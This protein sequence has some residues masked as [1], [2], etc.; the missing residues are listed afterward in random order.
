M[1]SWAQSAA[2]AGQIV[3][4]DGK[5]VRQ[6]LHVLRA[7]PAAYSVYLQLARAAVRYLPVKNRRALERI[8]ESDLWLS[9]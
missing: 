2:S 3:R 7:N 4:G 6:H 5:T 8:L 9:S 1:R